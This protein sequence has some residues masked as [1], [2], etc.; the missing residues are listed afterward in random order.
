M[1]KFIE[2]YIYNVKFGFITYNT[3]NLCLEGAFI[4]F[5]HLWLQSTKHCITFRHQVDVKQNKDEKQRQQKTEQ[6]IIRLW[7][8]YT[9]KAKTKY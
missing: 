6:L 4:S 7:K 9:T 5:R 1:N 2:K 3:K 8:D